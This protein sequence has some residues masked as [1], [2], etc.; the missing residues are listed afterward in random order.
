MNKLLLIFFI[1]I[2]SCSK[3]TSDRAHPIT[4]ES[5]DPFA[6][7]EHAPISYL[8]QQGKIEAA[9]DAIQAQ[10]QINPL[11]FHAGLLHEMAASCIIH[12]L[13]STDEDI[14]LALYAVAIMHDEA[15]LH[16]IEPVILSSNP[17]IQLIACRILSSFE[18]DTANHMLMKCLQSDF[19]PI[20]LEAAL[21]IAQRKLPNALEQ[22]EALYWK[23]DQEIK[24]AIVSLFGYEGSYEATQFLHRLLYNEDINTRLASILAIA[25]CE[26]QET[27][28]EQIAVLDDPDP[29]IQEACAFALGNSSS[30]A[31]QKKLEALCH[32][33][34]EQVVL[35]ASYSLYRQGIKEY[36]DLIEQ[37]AEDGNPFALYLLASLHTENNPQIEALIQS[38]DYLISLNAAFATL[39]KSV[40]N[41]F[42]NFQD[43]FLQTNKDLLLETKLS[44]GRTLRCMT[45]TPSKYAQDK[46][47]SELIQEAGRQEK[48]E[49]LIQICEKEPDFFLNLSYLIFKH[50]QNE[51][52]PAVAGL[53]ENLRSDDAITLL[54]AGREKLGAPLIRAYCNLSL[55]RITQEA[56]YRNQIVEWVKK[57]DINALIQVRPPLP[58]NSLSYNTPHTLTLE[59]QSRLLADSL[60]VLAQT[61]DESAIDQLLYVLKAGNPQNRSIIAALLSQCAR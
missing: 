19:L 61:Q 52:V 44:P 40:E 4:Y 42:Y 3:N 14:F 30:L 46:Y 26:P 7:Q 32:A 55:F 57:S 33:M 53:L 45:V 5:I 21:E 1:L 50:N 2:T 15:L 23:S 37:L 6:A 11:L 9:V 47:A 10:I 48:E 49:L 20:R 31:S 18:S 27:I 54:K 12:S 16:S 28:Y 8:I 59:E 56:P 29:R 22:I 51:L 39:G 60:E 17:F 25:M 41:K 43:L 36:L 34:D 38:D 13:K 24:P 58:W 35:A